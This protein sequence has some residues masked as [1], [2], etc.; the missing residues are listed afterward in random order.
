MFPLEKSLVD[1]PNDI[2]DELRNQEV[3]T[4]IGWTEELG[5][6]V[7]QTCGQGPFVIW[8]EKN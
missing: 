3:P 4:G 5:V 1:I 6:Y 2:W 8:S 7:L